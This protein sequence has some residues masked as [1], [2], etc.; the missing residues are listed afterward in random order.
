M[1]WLKKE[2]EPLLPRV[3]SERLCKKLPVVV[4]RT[5]QLLEGKDM[6]HLRN[7]RNQAQL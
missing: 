4:C 1:S 6:Q 5:K 3:C 7:K 2:L